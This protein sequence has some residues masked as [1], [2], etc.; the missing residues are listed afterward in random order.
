MDKGRF[1]IGDKV[2]HSNRP[3]TI[4]TVEKVFKD[5]SYRIVPINEDVKYA[6]TYATEDCMEMVTDDN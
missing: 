2:R 4:Y 6:I 5:G 3:N 1:K